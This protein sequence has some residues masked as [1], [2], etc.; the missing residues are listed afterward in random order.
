MIYIKNLAKIIPVFF[1][2]NYRTKMIPPLVLG[3]LEGAQGFKKI[4]SFKG[5]ILGG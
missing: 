3:W 1:L 5:R 2:I 4:Y